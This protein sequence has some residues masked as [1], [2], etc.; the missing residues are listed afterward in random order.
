MCALFFYEIRCFLTCVGS[1]PLYNQ[2]HIAAC[3]RMD[4]R[5]LEC[6]FVWIFCI[7]N[8]WMRLAV[9]VCLCACVTLSLID[10]CG[11]S[12]TIR[13][14]RT[15]HTQALLKTVHEFDGTVCECLRAPGR[16]GGRWCVIPQAWPSPTSLLPQQNQVVSTQLSNQPNMSSSY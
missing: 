12:R 13:R 4:Y 7:V 15:L 8:S 16:D 9:S 10:K 1:C 14:R 5:V 11:Q 2:P 3:D 6:M